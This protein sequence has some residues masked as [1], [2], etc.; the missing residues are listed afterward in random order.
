MSLPP[1]QGVILCDP[2]REEDA[3]MMA[4]SR[5]WELPK[6]GEA[7]GIDGRWRASFLSLRIADLLA[8]LYTD[9]RLRALCAQDRAWLKGQCE[10]LVEDAGTHFDSHPGDWQYQPQ[11]E[12]EYDFDGRTEAE[13]R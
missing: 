6:E 1:G 9:Q 8:Q 7:T 10:Q 12:P 3:L 13:V 2:S 4:T 11:D 5:E